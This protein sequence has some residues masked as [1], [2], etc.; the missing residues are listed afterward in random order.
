MQ[1]KL[2]KRAATRIARIGQDP[3][4][5]SELRLQKRIL[6]AIALLVAPA[7]VVWGM[8]YWSFGERLSALF[9][10]AYATGSLLSL[11]IFSLNRHFRFFRFGQLA[12]I[13]A[14]PFL[15]MISLGGVINSSAVILWSLLAPLGALLV[16][17]RRQSVNWFV[18]YVVL[19]VTSRFLE[20]L[21]RSSNNL[22][23]AAI[24]IFFVMNLVGPSLIVY[25]LV[26]YFVGQKDS[27]LEELAHE[28]GRSEEL[29]LNVLP[30]K[31]AA[32]RKDGVGTIAEQYDSISVMF[33]DMVG[34][35]PLSS[36][37]A[38]KEM[39]DLLAEVFTFF[40]FLVEKYDVEK[41]RTIGD[42]YMVAAG[43]PRRRPDHA[44]VLARMALDMIVFL[45]QNADEEVG[46]LKFRIGINSGS[47]V[48]GVIGLKKFQFDLWGDAV[49]I[50][51]RMESLGEPGKIK[52]APG[53]YDLIKYEFVCTP[54]GKIAVKGR[55][56]L[57]T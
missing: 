47:V 8:I 36:E 39:V 15:L 32:Q 46:R 24:L 7:A 52:I 40:D 29:L 13:L 20:P 41:I 3:T 18:G 26:I 16:S 10:L 48:V 53:T 33:A 2:W 54:R 11:S 30:K 27:A 14:L 49:N 23:P 45:E 21:V 35:A 31:I 28:Q 42:N 55:G 22:P 50:A 6:T 4:D 19:I 1:Q 51:A 57:N 37:L 9:P 34:F 56:E 17:G 43:V 12:L 44:N 25:I 5:S 38:P